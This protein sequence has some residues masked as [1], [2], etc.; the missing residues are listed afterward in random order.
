[1]KKLWKKW[2]L[3]PFPLTIKIR[4]MPI[5]HNLES[6]NV[7]GYEADGKPITCE[8][9]KDQCDQAAADIENGNYH[10]IE[11]LRKEMKEW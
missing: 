1:L 10:T 7:V 8:E 3:T 5:N 9:L 11:E 4:I 6:D 2:K